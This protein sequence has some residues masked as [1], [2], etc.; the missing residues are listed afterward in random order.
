MLIIIIVFILQYILASYLFLD[1]TASNQTKNLLK[2]NPSIIYGGL[3]IFDGNLAL[4]LDE[5]GEAAIQI[6][7]NN[8]NSQDFSLLN[9]TIKNLSHNYQVNFV[10]IADDNKP[11]EQQLT[12]ANGQLQS[13]LLSRNPLWKGKIKQLGLKISPQKHLGLAKPLAKKIILD[14]VYLSNPGFFKDFSLLASYW[15][16]YEGW[17]YRSINHLKLNSTLPS[18]AQ[19]LIFILIWLVI[20]LLVSVLFF[21]T[22]VNP[23]I[24]IFI[25]WLFLDIIF[26]Q[27]LHQ[28]NNWVL[29]N[30]SDKA[31]SL[32]DKELHELALQVKSLL[33]L[34][35]NKINKVLILSS[36]RYQRARL[37]Y[38]MLPANSSFLDEY[39]EKD[40]I[41]NVQSG[42]YILS[43]D[44][45]NN[46][47]R[48]SLGTLRI[49][50]LAINVK[51]IAHGTHF[52]I[53][54]VTND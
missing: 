36:D 51:E 42:D 11:I 15:F 44:T 17:N 52:S 23:F 31:K 35:N 33:G 43:Y 28:K 30:Y 41:A 26:L 2:N 25:A 24:Y 47:E 38:H 39:M 54:K 22:R 8:F 9:F 32:P 10:W 45:S 48:P 34:N 37:I 53:M 1:T 4:S 40:T 49:N 19:P 7:T 16:Q 6:S 3:N 13:Q 12:Q 21:K 50:Q 27:N 14:S 46:P 20:S 29:E 5:L 18:Y